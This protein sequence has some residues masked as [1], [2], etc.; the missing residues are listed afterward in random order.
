MIKLSP[1]WLRDQWPEIE[2]R[3]SLGC[4]YSRTDRVILWSASFDQL[5]V[6]CSKISFVIFL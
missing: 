3:R 6:M 2:T 4:S 5:I 1:R